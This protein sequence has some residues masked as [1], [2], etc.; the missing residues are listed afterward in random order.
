MQKNVESVGQTLP[1]PWKQKGGGGH[2]PKKK[3]FWLFMILKFI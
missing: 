3:V 2:L 1:L